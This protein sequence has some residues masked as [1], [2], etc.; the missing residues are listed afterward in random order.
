[1]ISSRIRDALE[2]Y[3]GRAVVEDAGGRW[4]LTGD[5]LLGGAA[6]LIGAL[7]PYAGRPFV[8]HLHKSPLYYAFTACAFLN[9]L[10]YCPLDISNP[11]ERVLDVAGQ[12]TGSLILCDDDEVFARLRERT[13]RCL[14]IGLSTED[15][16]HGLAG[17]QEDDG[18]RVASYYI[19]TSGSTG[20]PKLVKVPHERT[21][22]FIDWA[23][24]FYGIDRGT[25]WAQ[26]SSIGFDLSLVDFLC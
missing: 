24:P 17:V 6:S 22:P 12:L 19:A 10:D 25:R 23:V 13:Q 5:E 11:V 1:M 15:I 7:K 21:T 14:K 4:R 18:G 26:F 20:L 3:G 2:S 8:A 9:G 16:K